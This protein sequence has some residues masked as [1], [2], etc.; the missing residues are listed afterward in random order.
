MNTFFRISALVTLAA[1]NAAFIT[2]LFSILKLLVTLTP[3]PFIFF[4]TLFA[5][6]FGFASILL[7]SF[8][9]DELFGDK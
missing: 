5:F 6:F 8:F 1:L 9:E 3:T 7:H 4:D 2:T